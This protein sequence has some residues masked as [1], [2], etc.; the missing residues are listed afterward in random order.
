M[1]RLP[2]RHEGIANTGVFFPVIAPWCVHC[3]DLEPELESA[4]VRALAQDWPLAR[5][6]CEEEK[7]LCR[8]YRIDIYPTYITHLSRQRKVNIQ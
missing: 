7:D 8:E 2:H 3:Q 4:A 1:R 5:V 6:D